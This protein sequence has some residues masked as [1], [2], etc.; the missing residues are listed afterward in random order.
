MPTV[1]KEC[2]ICK[3][4]FEAN[5]SDAEVCS[6]ACRQKNWRLKKDAALAAANPTPE[7]KEELNEAEFSRLT[8]EIDRLN[9]ENQQ[10]RDQ[11]EAIKDQMPAPT[12]PAFKNDVER[13]IWES[14]VNQLKKNK[15]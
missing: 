13:M 8:S 2:V 7:E 15:K 11:I 12:Q 4:P 5:R 6:A 14:T 9:T 1:T 3:T 10:L